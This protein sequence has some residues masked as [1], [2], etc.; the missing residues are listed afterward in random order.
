[1]TDY[2]YD[3][4]EV[5]GILHDYPRLRASLKDP[6]R[7]GKP[8]NGFPSARKSPREIFRILSNLHYC[9]LRELV[10]LIEDSLRHGWRQQ[11]ILNTRSRFEFDS[12]LAVLRVAEYLRDRGAQPRSA[13]AGY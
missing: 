13:A 10:Q 7:E 12:E 3:P 6:R 11:A 9:H 2:L 5:N 1:M 4:E 8:S